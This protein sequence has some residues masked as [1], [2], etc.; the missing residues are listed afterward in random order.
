MKI[1]LPFSVI[2]YNRYYMDSELHS[3]LHSEKRAAWSK[4][5]HAVIIADKK[6]TGMTIA[7]YLMWYN[8]ING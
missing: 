7:V 2:I 4:M 1:L 5:L 3:E 6:Y 8:A